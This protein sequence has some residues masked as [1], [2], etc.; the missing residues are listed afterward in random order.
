MKTR[1]Q[2]KSVWAINPAYLG[3]M[4]VKLNFRIFLC[5]HM[6][7]E[8][9]CEEATSIFSITKSANWWLMNH[10]LYLASVFLFKLDYLILLKNAE[11]PSMI[12]IYDFSLNVRIYSNI[13][14]TLL[15][16]NCSLDLSEFQTF[17][18][19]HV[20]SHGPCSTIF[21]CK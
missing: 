2:G 7:K 21:Y 6:F 15:Y 1:I 16:G 10:M 14:P 4:H 3:K 5:S 11:D 17:K 19:G 12:K 8:L 13:R 18:K 9:I 20:L